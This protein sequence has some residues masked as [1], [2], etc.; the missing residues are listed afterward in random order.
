MRSNSQKYDNTKI[1]NQDNKKLV[2]S[3]ST[4]ESLEIIQL[5]EKIK[6]KEVELA[7]QKK[8]NSKFRAVTIFG[9]VLLAVGIPLVFTII[10]TAVFGPAFLS[11]LAGLLITAPVGVLVYAHIDIEMKKEVAETQNELDNFQKELEELEKSYGKGK[12][13]DEVE[14]KKSASKEKLQEQSTKQSKVK[15]TKH[16]KEE[17]NLDSSSNNAKLLSQILT[18]KANLKKMPIKNT[19]AKEQI[20]KDKPSKSKAEQLG[21]KREQSALTKNRI[22]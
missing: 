5:S 12:E 10:F 21:E 13:K 4:V 8:S 18:K 19:L 14:V 20:I 9:T 15:D 22:R 1:L 6:R 17:K 16:Q 3:N 2:E 7:K 11:L